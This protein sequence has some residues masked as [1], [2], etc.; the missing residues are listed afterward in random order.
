MD[1][2]LFNK[3][4]YN[5]KMKKRQ[6]VI[7]LFLI[8]CFNLAS[9]QDIKLNKLFVKVS[10]S[11]GD[12]VTNTIEVMSES[13]GNIDFSVLNLDGVSLENNRLYL[14]SGE[15]RKIN[16]VFDSENLNNG[17][18]TGVLKIENSGESLSLPIIFEVES[19]DPF[20]DF[21]LDIPIQSKEITPGEKVLAQI[22]IFDLVRGGTSEGLGP[23]KLNIEYLI[24]SLEGDVVTSQ[25][26]EI[27]LNGEVRVD[28]A[29]LLPKEI[30]K[31]D[32]L[33]AVIVK[34]FDLESI[35]S[36]L[37]SVVEKEEKTN[38]SEKPL[39]L[40]FVLLLLVILLLFFG[41]F[42]FLV[43][44]IRD[45]D[46]LFLDLKRYNS[47]ESIAQDKFL[48]DQAKVAKI[49]AT[50]KKQVERIDKEIEKKK[51]NL[52]KK[53][54]KRI[55]ELTKLKGEGKNEKMKKKL[56]EWKS[57]GYDTS[58]LEYKL[59]ML[60]KKDMSHILKKWKRIK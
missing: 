29:I 51:E 27:I 44:F 8:L 14:N 13:G 38:I 33:L 40:N 54:E 25:T 35:S 9:A 32:Y 34:S 59:G 50:S 49:K 19:K 16:I 53:Q 31:G 17:I 24:Y 36:D 4:S 6:L 11:Q 5:G 12:Y 43:Y 58:A 48:N 22:K 37:F 39:D 42:M 46:R 7:I 1:K 28:R 15:T 18:Y 41:M 21:S 10:V 57:K 55:E 60:S 20:F 26:E 2:T 56:K 47:Q 3:V 30:P 23:T 52:K 45:R